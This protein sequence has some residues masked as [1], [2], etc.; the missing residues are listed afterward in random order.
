MNIQ[1][2]EMQVD[3]EYQKSRDDTNATITVTQGS[4]V[5]VLEYL[6]PNGKLDADIAYRKIWSGEIQI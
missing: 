1:G 6:G 3:I 4:K 5:T 2:N